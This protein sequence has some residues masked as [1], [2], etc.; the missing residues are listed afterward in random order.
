MR[1]KTKNRAVTPFGAVLGGAIAFCAAGAAHAQQQYT[2]W[3]TYG[4]GAH[5]AQYS[6]LKQINKSNASQ[7]QVAGPSPSPARFI[8][9]PLVVDG[10]MYLQARATM[11]V[12]LDAETGKEIWRTERRQRSAR[13]G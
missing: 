7:L 13:A 9:N 4:G 8:F 6:A 2:T 10:M 5:S 11:L 1:N 12:A 3:R